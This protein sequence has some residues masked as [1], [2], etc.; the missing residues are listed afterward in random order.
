M[1]RLILLGS[2]SARYTGKLLDRV[3][4]ALIAE[5]VERSP[6]YSKSAVFGASRRGRRNDLRVADP[7]KLAERDAAE[8]ALATRQRRD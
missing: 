6:E 1:L 7:D 5:K 2:F 8:S 4:G 3:I